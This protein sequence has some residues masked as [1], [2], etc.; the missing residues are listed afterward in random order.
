M[1]VLAG[2]PGRN[3]RRLARWGALACTLA[4]LIPFEN[5][6]PLWGF[7]G[8]VIDLATGRAGI[9][10]DRAEWLIIA[11][12]CMA[13]PIFLGGPAY[14]LFCNGAA[15]RRDADREVHGIVMKC[16]WAATALTPYLAVFKQLPARSPATETPIAIAISVLSAYLLVCG[17]TYLASRRARYTPLY[18]FSMGIL[19]IAIMFL[20]WTCFMVFV[21][22]IAF[23]V[24]PGGWPRVATVVGFAG[25]LALL[26]GWR[27]W[28]RAV[29]LATAAVAVPECELKSKN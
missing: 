3:W 28:W 8:E 4:T 20:G 19:P 15:T 23:R 6:T 26:I 17:L 25:S 22:L 1:Q 7:I 16:L 11:F 27:R 9:S 21:T 29:K 5:G 14:L 10:R 18:L 13:A 12:C 24:S 2:D